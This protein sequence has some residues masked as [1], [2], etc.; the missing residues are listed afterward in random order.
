MGGP[1]TFLY[2]TLPF[3]GD[4]RRVNCNIIARADDTLEDHNSAHHGGVHFTC[5]L[6][7]KIFPH[8]IKVMIATDFK[9]ICEHAL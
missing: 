4:G 6:G 2:C 7:R 1:G 3:V 8:S 5:V 9:S